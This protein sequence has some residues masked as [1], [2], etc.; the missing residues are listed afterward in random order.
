M[1]CTERLR[2]NPV[3]F[4]VAAMLAGAQL[5]APAP[6]W[7]QVAGPVPGALEEVGVEEHLGAMLPLDLR[8]VD[9]AG[10]DVRLG[11]LFDGEHPVIL[12][13]NYYRCRM[14]CGL[15][16]NGLVAGLAEL[17]WTAGDRFRVVT[18]SINPLET[19]ALAAGKKQSYIKAYGR[20]AAAKGWSF[21]TGREKDIKALAS[22]VGFGYR[23]DPAERQYAH[24]AVIFVVAPDG[25]VVRYL[26]GIDYPARRLRLALLEAAEGRIGS[27][28]DQ[29]LL[30]CYHYDPSSRRYAPVAMNIMRLGGGMTVLVLGG[31]LGLLW[32]RESRRRRRSGLDSDS[33]RTEQDQD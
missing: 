17:D 5:L 33:R 23:Y 14:L 30:F 2:L 4:F 15:Q 31:A 22:A 29:V 18:V 27:P 8:F 1:S 32:F 7:S 26:Y 3:L 9:S 10:R 12:T 20:P 13:L 19:P 6:A 28:F 11:D 24:A 25:E 16:L 21:L